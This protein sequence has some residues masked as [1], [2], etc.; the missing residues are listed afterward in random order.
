M[1]NTCSYKFQICSAANQHENARVKKI[2]EF[3]GIWTMFFDSATAHTD[4]IIRNPGIMENRGKETRFEK[5]LIPI[6][7]LIKYNP[8]IDPKTLTR[9][10]PQIGKNLLFF[11]FWFN[12]CSYDV[13]YLWIFSKITNVANL[14]KFGH[15]F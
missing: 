9:V 6:L 3:L 10:T 1:P 14:A 15:S 11:D 5:S 7:I 4:K 2:S 12:I 8:T 13:N